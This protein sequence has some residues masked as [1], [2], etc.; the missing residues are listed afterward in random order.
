MIALLLQLQSPFAAQIQALSIEAREKLIEERLLADPRQFKSIEW[1]QVVNGAS[2]HLKIQV[3]PDYLFVGP[4]EDPFYVPLTP[5]TAQRVAT[6]LACILPTPR[7]VDRIYALAGRKVEPIPIPPTP[8]MTTVAIF[9]EHS[10][11]VRDQLAGKDLDQVIAGNKKD[12]VICK[13]L[14][15]TFGKVAI[16]GWHKLDGKPIQPLYLG[17]T[18]RWADYS[19]G[20]RLI[21]NRAELDGKPVLLTNLLK[22]PNL[23]ALVS[24]EG[25]LTQTEYRFAE[26]P[27]DGLAQIK[28]DADELLTEFSPAKGVRAVIHRL[29]VI[30]KEIEVAVFAL[31]NGNSIENTFGRKL[32]EGMDWH[33]DIQHIGAQ[34]RWLWHAAGRRDL[35]VVYLEN[36]QKSWPTW[37]R[38][39]EPS[40]AHAL[41]TAIKARFPGSSIRWT[42]A[43]HSGGGAL[44]LSMIKGWDSIPDD[45]ERICFLDSNYNY[46]T[47]THFQK[48]WSWLTR[49]KSRL[50]VFA[51]DDANALLNGKPFVSASGGTWGRTHLMMEDFQKHSPQN[52]Q[53]GDPEQRSYV[54]GKAIFWLKP[55]PKHE[56]FHTVQVEK[57]GF[58]EALLSGTPSA[59]QGYSYFGDRAYGKFVRE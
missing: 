23:A 53:H 51:Y 18:A 6:S 39:H 58:I 36:S 21:L 52:T 20:V 38:S 24:D 4:R 33:F 56:I 37:S 27:V 13:A 22:D 43:S 25:P 1:D 47:L 11:L 28:P 57:N 41:L 49:P 59:G 31:P 35:V 44:L 30:P 29:K 14:A 12:I 9:H 15:T 3:Q 2:H 34:T 17:H 8:A 32:R 50:T 40:E 55:N 10:K 45:V 26:F 19:H 5:F 54:N 48:L 46:D 7:L 16:Y 42:L